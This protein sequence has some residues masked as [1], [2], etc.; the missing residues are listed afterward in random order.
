MAKRF[1][2]KV[3][4]LGETGVGKTALV[5]RFVHDKFEEKYKPTIGIDI[6]LKRIT[7]DDKKVQL[8]IWDIGGQ[9]HFRMV[10]RNYLLGAAGAIFVY[11]LTKPHTFEKLVDWDKELVDVLRKEKVPYILIGNKLDLVETTHPPPMRFPPTFHEELCVTNTLVSAKWGGEAIE[12]A[13]L[14]LSQA[15]V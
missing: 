10:R 14:L 15:A 4:T 5:D 9:E 13:F 12:N 2:I 11:D 8:Q 1:I 6:F 7:L 3:V